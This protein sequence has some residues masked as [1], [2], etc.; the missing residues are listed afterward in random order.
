MNVTKSFIKS[1]KN[2]PGQLK[3]CVFSYNIYSSSL[4]TEFISMGAAKGADGLALLF[5]SLIH[6]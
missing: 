3:V 6:I 2:L 1:E 4:D 5:L